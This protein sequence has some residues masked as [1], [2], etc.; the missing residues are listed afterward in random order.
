MWK[1]LRVSLLAV[2]LLVVAGRFVLDRYYS[3]AWNSTLW[4]A[5]FPVNADG[6]AVT[7]SYVDALQAEQFASIETFFAREAHRYGVN[8]P[9]PVHVQLMPVVTELPP[10]LPKGAGVATIALW[11]LKLRWYAWRYGSNSISRVRVF[12]LYHDPERTPA[13]PHSLGLQKGLVGVVYGFADRSMTGTNAIVVVHEVLHTLGATDHYDLATG[14]PLYPQG[15][16]QPDLQPRHPQPVAEIMA[17]R[18][19]LT[20][21]TAEMPESLAEVAVGAVTASEINW[22]FR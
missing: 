19:A 12:V 18:R 22:R 13:V 4:V 17:G 16:A 2:L 10:Q 7:R 3:R 15:Y 5:V 1:I 6:S 8:L 20:S 21:A 14:Q 11:S 9:K